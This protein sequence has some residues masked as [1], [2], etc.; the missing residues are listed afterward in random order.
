MKFLEKLNKQ[1]AEEKEQ[2]IKMK[3]R[4]ELIQEKERAR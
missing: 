1:R 4:K 2:E 3:K